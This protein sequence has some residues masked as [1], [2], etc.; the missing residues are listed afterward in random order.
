MGELNLEN[1]KEYK[2]EILKAEIGALLFNLGKTHVG[3]SFWS[4]YF[5]NSD[6]KWASYKEYVDKYLDPE[7]EGVNKQLKDFINGVQ[8]KLSFE[9]LKL[10][11][12]MQ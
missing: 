3:F 11:E 7:L 9:S 1:L 10:K 2:D 4:P 8:V 12:I 5:P 6:Y